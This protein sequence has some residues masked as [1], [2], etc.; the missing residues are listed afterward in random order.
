MARLESLRYRR[1]RVLAGW[2]I[3]VLFATMVLSSYVIFIMGPAARGPE[4][5][6]LLRDW[7][8]LAADGTV[9]GEVQVP[10]HLDG[11]VDRDQTYRLRTQITLPPAFRG[12]ALTLSVPRLEAQTELEVD[13]QPM[14]RLNGIQTD[15]YRVAGPH[16]WRI[17]ASATKGESLTFVLEVRHRWSQSGWIDVAPRLSATPAGDAMDRSQDTFNALTANAALNTVI[18]CGFVYGI[19]FLFDRRQRAHG[20]FALEAIGG[21]FYPLF[22]LGLAEQLFGTADAAV[23]ALMTSLA[24]VASVY[25]THAQFRLASP[26][27]FI[28]LGFCVVVFMCLVG[29][30][31]YEVTRL[32]SPVTVVAV[33]I[34]IVYQV[35][36]AIRALAQEKQRVRAASLLVSWLALGVSSV[37]DFVSWCGFGEVLGGTHTAAVGIWFIAILQGALLSWDHAIALNRADRLNRQLHERVQELEDRKRE[38]E[39]KRREVDVL[40]D[41][42]RRQM[43][44]RSE[45]L[46][47]AL[48]RLALRTLRSAALVPGVRIDGRYEVVKELGSGAMGAVYE[49]VRLLD[50]ARLAM[51]VLTTAGNDQ[52]LAR[53][54]REAQIF[55][56]LHH[57]NVVGIVD[58]E[59]SGDGQFYLVTELVEGSPLRNLRH[60]FGDLP[61]ALDILGQVAEGLQE[62]HRAGVVHRDLKPGNILIDDKSGR[63]IA[64]IADFGISTIRSGDTDPPWSEVASPVTGERKGRGDQNHTVMAA[65]GSS[66]NAG[67]ELTATGVLMGTP[68]YMAPELVDGARSAPPSSDVFSFGVLAYEVL[69]GHMPYV[70]PPAQARLDGRALATPIALSTR[71]PELDLRVAHLVDSAA[72]LDPKAR[73]TV[74]ELIQAL[75]RS[76]ALR[77]AGT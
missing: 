15:A 5:V 38:A 53:F 31:R 12:D 10:A 2:T 26:P 28:I 27:R 60:R 29:G 43:A 56:T 54:A 6:V 69:S 23:L 72:S 7:T 16:R 66:P 49:V 46:A 70:E 74:A 24:M 19:L 33:A 8:V 3:A 55:A 9:R 13:G 17:P 34:N 62:I 59:V 11:L 47:G 39:T 65:R 35:R 22:E 1:A 48:S 25:F 41:E 40:N 30:G 73:P 64:K 51:K 50:G 77:R 45:Q 4:S 58:V 44:S 63:P 61:W 36:I 20:W 57:P 42:L 37:P 14:L 76:T 18:G 32:L 52:E 21:A 71:C 67:G 68:R 75:R